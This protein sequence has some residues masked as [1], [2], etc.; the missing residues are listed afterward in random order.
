[1]LIG[2]HEDSSFVTLLVTFDNQGLEYQCEDGSWVGVA[3]RPGSPYILE[4][5][6]LN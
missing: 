4:S 2:E 5:S 1:M 6:C 3:P